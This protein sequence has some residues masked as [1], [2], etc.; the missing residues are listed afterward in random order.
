MLVEKIMSCVPEIEMKDGAVTIETLHNCN[1][2]SLKA[3]KVNEVLTPE[4]ASN[5]P[6]A[7]SVNTGGSLFTVKLNG[8]TSVLN[9]SHTLISKKCTPI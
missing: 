7:G 4:V 8:K 6:G 3:G 9:E 5:L 1:S 2:G